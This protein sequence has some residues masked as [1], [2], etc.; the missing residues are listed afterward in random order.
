[1]RL[2]VLLI[3]AA[4]VSAVPLAT[5]ESGNALSGRTGEFLL[6]GIAICP[7][8]IIPVISFHHSLG[9]LTSTVESSADS[10]EAVAYPAN[11]DQSW[12]DAA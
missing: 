4:T 8:E 10:D 9:V 12:V 11:I 6:S 7:S 2:N 5:R 1:M 3:L